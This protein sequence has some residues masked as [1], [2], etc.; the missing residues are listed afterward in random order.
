MW[1]QSHLLMA[2]RVTK[3][4]LVQ[5]IPTTEITQLEL[6]AIADLNTQLIILIHIITTNSIWIADILDHLKVQTEKPY[7]YLT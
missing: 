6:Q 7:L 2:V 4:S 1:A 3:N 5:S